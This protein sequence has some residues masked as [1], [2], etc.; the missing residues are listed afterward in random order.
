VHLKLLA[1]N[2]EGRE[3]RLS[4][5]AKTDDIAYLRQMLLERGYRL[6]EII[7]PV[8]N[9][10][11]GAEGHLAEV[12]HPPGTSSET[13][14]AN[15]SQEHDLE[16]PLADS[17]LSPEASDTGIEVGAAHVPQFG[18]M[19]LDKNKP[20]TSGLYSLS[21]MLVAEKHDMVYAVFASEADANATLREA[22][23][24][25]S[26]AKVDVANIVTSII[27]KFQKDGIHSRTFMTW[28]PPGCSPLDA[29]GGVY[30]EEFTGVK[31]ELSDFDFV[32]DWSDAHILKNPMHA[33]GVV[34]SCA[35]SVYMAHWVET[36]RYQFAFQAIEKA[37]GILQ[38]LEEQNE[39]TKGMPPPSKCSICRESDWEIEKISTTRQS[40]IYKCTFCG[41]K[42]I[43]TQQD[44]AQPESQV[45][46]DSI[47]REVQ[48]FV[49]RRDEGKCV[50]CASVENLEFDHII[51]HSRGGANTSRNLQ[52]L[53]QRCNRS[54]SD[55]EPGAF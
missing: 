39:A 1:T 33:E 11:Q 20:D 24:T 22:S 48:G 53:C 43:V 32:L 55:A 52:L 19:V 42:H 26:I 31:V 17:D 7:N 18:Y 25:Y 49:W 14:P 46:R 54:K 9:E 38:V 29:F 40:V 47:P 27:L 21:E 2:Q 28:P 45:R 23:E 30:D 50:R 36:Q 35:K 16:Q 4:V 5:Q 15:K 10:E 8:S 34:R 41:R 44:P 37:M 13:A 12:N 51:P 6:I 3:R